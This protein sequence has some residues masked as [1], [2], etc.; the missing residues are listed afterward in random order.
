MPSPQAQGG[1][2]KAEGEASGHRESLA[3]M[4][5]FL[6][7]IQTELNIREY[8]LGQTTLEEI[9][10]RFAAT[11]EE[12]VRVARGMQM[13]A[14]TAASPATKDKA[15]KDK[16]SSSPTAT[17]PPGYGTIEMTPQGK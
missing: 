4:F 1:E 7:G 17:S 3:A 13:G 6:N 12:E 9:F 10:N 14:I 2:V 5:S 15:T 8:S 11:Q 16:A